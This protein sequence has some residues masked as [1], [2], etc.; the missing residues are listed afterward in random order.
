ML[1]C[2]REKGLIGTL[3]LVTTHYVVV[4]IIMVILHFVLFHSSY[5]QQTRCTHKTHIHTQVLAFSE[6]IHQIHNTIINEH[7]HA[8][9]NKIW[10]T[11]Q[12]WNGHTFIL[13]KYICGADIYKSH[14]YD[15]LILS[16]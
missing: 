11:Q 7:K 14:W 4:C 16:C 9:N 3:C 13:T 5:T 1:A 6:T 2:V 12:M 8:F 15:G 10:K